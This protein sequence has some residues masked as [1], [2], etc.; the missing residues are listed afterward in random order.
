MR[1]P[2]LVAA[3]ASMFAACGPPRVAS[4]NAAAFAAQRLTSA[5][6]LVRAGCL[7]CLIDAFHQ[8]DALRTVPSASGVATAAAARTA[9]LI[10]VRERELGTEDTGTLTRARELATSSPDLA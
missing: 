6:S 4:P 9:A 7:D 2:A 8:Y 3:G 5:A 10:A 1:V